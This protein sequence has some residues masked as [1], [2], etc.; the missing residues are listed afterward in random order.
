MQ[1]LQETDS[2]GLYFLQPR[3]TGAV[4][5]Y[6]PRNFLPELLKDVELQTRI[7][8][9]FVHDGAP[10]HFLLAVREFL[11][12]VLPE[13][14]MEGCWPRAWSALSS[15]IFISRDIWSLLFVLQSQWHPGLEQWKHNGFYMICTTPGIFQLVRQLLFRCATSCVEVQGGYFWAFSLIF[16]SPSLGNH[17]SLRPRFMNYFS[18]IVV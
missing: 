6:F 14:W 4:Y 11:N 8:L 12:N 3:L 15:Y 7:H 1:T 5:H 13:Q 17:A 10:P 9:W 16:T 2:L 18:Y